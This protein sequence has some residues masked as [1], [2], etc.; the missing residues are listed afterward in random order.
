[1]TQKLNNVKFVSF[2]ASKHPAM[3]IKEHFLLDFNFN[4][5]YSKKPNHWF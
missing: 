2:N 4:L 1:M 5:K 3:A